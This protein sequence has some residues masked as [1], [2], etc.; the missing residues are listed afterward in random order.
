MNLRA[1]H[2]P[3]PP[4]APPPRHRQALGRCAR[5][6]DLDFD[7]AVRRAL[8]GESPAQNPPLL[9]AN[10]DTA[11]GGSRGDGRGARGGDDGG[12]AEETKAEVKGRSGEGD[13]GGDGRRGSGAVADE[14]VI[15]CGCRCAWLLFRLSTVVRCSILVDVLVFSRC[16]VE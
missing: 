2:H 7:E 14:K 3:F 9:R 13:G 10:G 1:H 8:S 5:S 6:Q 4:L 11:N 16:I 15:G 12:A